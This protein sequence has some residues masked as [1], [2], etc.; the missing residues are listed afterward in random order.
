VKNGFGGVSDYI[1]GVSDT[2]N[3][4]TRTLQ[5]NM[6]VTKQCDFTFEAFCE[7]DEI[8]NMTNEDKEKAWEKLVNN[9]KRNIITID[10]GREEEIDWHEVEGDLELLVEEAIESQ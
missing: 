5:I 6:V 3:K 9:S 10:N 4:I 2:M 1:W 7:M 8:K